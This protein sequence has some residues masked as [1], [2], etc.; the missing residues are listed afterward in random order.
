VLSEALERPARLDRLRG[1]IRALRRPHA[2]REIAGHLL[3]L[4]APETPGRPLAA[5]RER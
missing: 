1:A 3:G 5:Y 4:V 2:A